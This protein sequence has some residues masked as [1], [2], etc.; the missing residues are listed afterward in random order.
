MPSQ[1]LA[2]TL[3]ENS[4][5][6]V[7]SRLGLCGSKVPAAI[8]SARKARTSL[9][10]CS[11]SSGKRIGSKRRAAV[12]CFSPRSACGH[13]R[14]QFIGATLGHELAELDGPVAFRTKVIAPSQRAQRIAVQN[15]LQREADGA[16]VLV[17]YGTAFFGSFRA[18][19]LC[20]GRFEVNLVVEGLC[21]RNGVGSRRRGRERC[22]G[23][24][25]KAR[26]IVLHRLEFRDLLLEGD[27]LVG[28]A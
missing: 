10:S 5:A 21:I 20:G 26:E 16:V 4:G 18:A 17:R 15:V 24:A 14:P 12:M 9:R 7:S 2:P 11:H 3:R 19:D 8:S 13:E 1:P 27:A 28:I 6:S 23:L 22:G 25:G